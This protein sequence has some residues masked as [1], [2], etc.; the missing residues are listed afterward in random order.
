[1]NHGLGFKHL[2][3][4][5]DRT[6]AKHSLIDDLLAAEMATARNHIGF[7]AWIVAKVCLGLAA[8][9]SMRPRRQESLDDALARLA[10]V[11]PHLLDDIGMKA[12]LLAIDSEFVPAGRGL[13]RCRL[14]SDEIEVSKSPAAAAKPVVEVDRSIRQPV[15]GL[16]PAE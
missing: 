11:S 8:V 4:A 7:R 14:V 3:D 2:L 6:G 13:V 12:D 9:G 10:N 1:M 16:A 5:I 15:I